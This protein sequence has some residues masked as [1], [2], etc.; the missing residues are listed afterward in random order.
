MN[1][2]SKRRGGWRDR[3]NLEVAKLRGSQKYRELTLNRL[4]DLVDAPSDTVLISELA[5]RVLQGNLTVVYRIVSPRTNASLAEKYKSLLDIPDVIVDDSTGEE[6][7]VDLV[8][9]VEAVYVPEAF[10]VR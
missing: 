6:F 9:N 8:Q 10:G 5:E 1:L 7:D 2:Y 3:L 4:K